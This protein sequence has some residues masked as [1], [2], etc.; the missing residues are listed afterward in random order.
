MDYRQTQRKKRI[1][2]GV[3][4]ETIGAVAALFLIGCLLTLSY[5]LLA[6]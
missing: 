1:F 2:K 6:E 3:M 5:A 4:I